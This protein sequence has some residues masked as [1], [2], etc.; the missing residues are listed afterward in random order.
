MSLPPCHDRTGTVTSRGENPQ[1]L[2][3]AARDAAER[4]DRLGDAL[5]LHNPVARGLR[6]AIALLASRVDVP[7]SPTTPNTS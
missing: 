2:V 6:D 4:V 1:S 5:S 7:N 3:M